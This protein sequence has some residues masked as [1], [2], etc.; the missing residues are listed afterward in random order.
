MRWLPIN[1]IE[2]FKIATFFVWFCK[3]RMLAKMFGKQCQIGMD[4][5]LIW[6][7]FS[8]IDRLCGIEIVNFQVAEVHLW[9]GEFAMHLCN[10]SSEIHLMWLYEKSR[11]LGFYPVRHAKNVHQYTQP[12]TQKRVN[13]WTLNMWM[14]K[15]ASST[16]I[17]ISHTCRTLN[18]AIHNQDDIQ[19]Y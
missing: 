7:F 1:S 5:T 16:S 17:K 12:H 4:R 6:V 13:M 3:M 2:E 18:D 11:S 15:K 14:G 19:F 8:H 9:L 10:N